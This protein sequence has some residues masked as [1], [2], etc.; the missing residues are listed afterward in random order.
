MVDLVPILKA[1]AQAY[2]LCNNKDGSSML[3][4]KRSKNSKDSVFNDQAKQIVNFLF[5]V[6]L[7]FLLFVNKCLYNFKLRDIVQLRDYLLSH[8]RQYVNIE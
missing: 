7:M 4:T 1:C 8:R 3:E 5:Y 6:I 2:K